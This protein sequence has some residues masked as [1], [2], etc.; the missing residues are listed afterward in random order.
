MRVTV[1]EDFMKIIM[2]TQRC[3]VVCLKNAIPI[4]PFR[5]ITGPAEYQDIAAQIITNPTPC[6]AAGTRHSGL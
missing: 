5:V 3:G 2:D 4:R 6:F 1:A